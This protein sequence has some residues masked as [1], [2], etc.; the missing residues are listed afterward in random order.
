LEAQ[1]EKA[2]SRSF[3]TPLNVGKEDKE[4]QNHPRCGSASETVSDRH[5]RGNFLVQYD[6]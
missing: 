1:Y 4:P 5:G 3:G 6:Y 2:M